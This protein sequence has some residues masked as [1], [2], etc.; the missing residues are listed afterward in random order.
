[1]A[2]SALLSWYTPSTALMST[3]I[4]MMNTSAK[5]SPE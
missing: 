4:R 2:F 5:L 3:T 1:M